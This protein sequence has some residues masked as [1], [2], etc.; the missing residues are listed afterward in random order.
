MEKSYYDILGVQKPDSDET[1]RKAWRK[2][3]VRYHPDKLAKK[4]PEEQREA[5]FKIKEINEAYETLGDSNKRQNYDKYGKNGPSGQQQEDFLRNLFTQQQARIPPI[6]LRARLSLEDLYNGKTLNNTVPRQS[7][8]LKCNNTGTHNGVSSPCSKCSGSG[9]IIQHI[10][11]GFFQRPHQIPCTECNGNGISKTTELCIN[12][13]GN[14]VYLEQYTLNVFL[15]KNN[16]KDNYIV[17]PNE[18]HEFQNVNGGNK[19]GDIVIHIEELP[20]KTFRKQNRDLFATVEISLQEALLGSRKVLKHLNGNDIL[21]VEENIIQP[22]EKKIFY[23][24]GFTNGGD[25]IVEYIVKFPTYIDDT[26]KAQLQAIFPTSSCSDDT[27]NFTV[28]KSVPYM[29]FS[30]EE[31]ETSNNPRLQQ[32]QCTPQ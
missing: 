12:C 26:Q 4:T 5:E 3:C 28:I 20:H 24:Y 23:N 11:N 14:K 8:C 21:L 9:R 32:V 19:R 6:E 29:E 22:N 31:N 7:V 10:Q 2:L 16:M 1:I 17:V 27:S 30:D 25:L 15:D 13:N 18:G